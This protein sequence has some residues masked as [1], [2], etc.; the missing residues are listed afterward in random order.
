[1]THYIPQNPPLSA[2]LAYYTVRGDE[3]GDLWAE[4]AVVIG[5]R[6]DG[7]S[8]PLPVVVGGKVGSIGCAIIHDD[9]LI[10]VDTGYDYKSRQEWLDAE[11]PDMIAAGDEPAPT[12]DDALA[13]LDILFTDRGFKKQSFWRF[14]GPGHAPFMF[15]VDA[16]DYIPEDPRVDKITRAD[17]QKNRPSLAEVPYAALFGAPQPRSA[18]EPEPEPDAGDYDETDLI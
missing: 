10:S 4:P 11:G 3:T 13:A 18:P 12:G 1:M 17:F 15:V 2:R 7:M 6:I 16:G 5:W 9:M 14:N 8:A